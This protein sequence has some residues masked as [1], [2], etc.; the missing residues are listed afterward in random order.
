MKRSS[1]WQLLLLAAAAAVVSWVAEVLLTGGGRGS[2]VPLPAF[3]V[4][5][6]ILAIVA[7]ALAWPV[8]AY[9]TR[10]RRAQRDESA[11]TA[12]R[13]A[14]LRAASA[15][16]PEPRMALLALAFAKASTLA[17]ALFSGA[18]AAVVVWLLT[19]TIVAGQVGEAVF[20][21]IASVLLLI[22]GL[23]A[24]SWC[25]LPPEQGDPETGRE[26]EPATPSFG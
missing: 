19:R 6:V 5:L 18:S 9:T 21:L 13:D 12:H 1:A 20:A 24:E 15:R 3:G 17:G 8:R 2:F 26:T 16:R 23:L 22:A 14:L 25:S 7:L 11:D 10:L 4:T